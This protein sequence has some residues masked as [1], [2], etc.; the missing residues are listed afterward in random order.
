M[1]KLVTFARTISIKTLKTLLNSKVNKGVTAFIDIFGFIVA[2]GFTIFHG[3]Q[4]LNTLEVIKKN[5]NRQKLK[6]LV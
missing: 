1:P 3:E 4:S 6:A 5:K 2:F